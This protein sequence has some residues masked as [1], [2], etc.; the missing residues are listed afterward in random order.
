M[1]EA[2]LKLL[3]TVVTGSGFSVGTQALTATCEFGG[4]ALVN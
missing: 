2:E 4:L 3:A 1:G